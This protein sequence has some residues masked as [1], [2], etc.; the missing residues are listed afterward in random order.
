MSSIVIYRY[1]K[2]CDGIFP[3]SYFVFFFFFWWKIEFNLEME[4][5]KCVLNE[6][7]RP[8]S[9]ALV[10]GFL[11]GASRGTS[12]NLFFLFPFHTFSPSWVTVRSGFILGLSGFTCIPFSFISLAF[13]FLL[14]I[15]EDLE[16]GDLE[17]KYFSWV[18]FLSL[19]SLSNFLYWRAC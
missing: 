16:P 18:V 1:S 3:E 2:V 11:D 9:L 7:T 14:E 10:N 5:V 12:Y 4:H 13:H 8:S 19:K 15:P 6:G 17:K